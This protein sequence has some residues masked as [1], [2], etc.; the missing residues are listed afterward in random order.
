MSSPDERQAA[1][2]ERRAP[3]CSACGVTAL[4]GSAVA[5]PYDFVCDNP[6]CEAF[7]EPVR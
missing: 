1:A 6:D 2:R 4:P 5:A 7:G 3:I